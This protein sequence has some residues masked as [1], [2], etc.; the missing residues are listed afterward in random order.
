[1]ERFEGYGPVSIRGSFILGGD[2]IPQVGIKF[3]RSGILVQVQPKGEAPGSGAADFCGKGAGTQG[4]A[5]IGGKAQGKQTGYGG[6]K[7]L[8]LE[9]Q[10]PEGEG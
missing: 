2:E 5:P 10:V 1:M 7:I 8:L 6:T 4:G 9:K 3:N